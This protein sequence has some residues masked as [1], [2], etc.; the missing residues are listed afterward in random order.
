MKLIEQVMGTSKFRINLQNLDIQENL[1]KWNKWKQGENIGLLRFIASGRITRQVAE[2]CVSVKYGRWQEY[3]LSG[4][5]RS[6]F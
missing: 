4:R 5:K 2:K 1:E 6:I 3:M